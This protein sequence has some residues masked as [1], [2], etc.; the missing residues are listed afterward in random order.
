MLELGPWKTVT[1][2][3]IKKVSRL[4]RQ[5]PRYYPEHFLAFFITYVKWYIQLERKWTRKVA[6]P[7]ANVPMA[8]SSNIPITLGVGAVGAAPGPGSHSIQ[9]FDELGSGESGARYAWQTP[10]LVSSTP[11]LPRSLWLTLSRM[12]GYLING[13]MC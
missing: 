3:S 13:T 11:D 2:Q 6:A 7:N 4:N 1:L 12:L 8:I 10:D 9:T 5:L